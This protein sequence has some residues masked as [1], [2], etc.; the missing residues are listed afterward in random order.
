MNK[1]IKS[2]AKILIGLCVYFGLSGFAMFNGADPSDIASYSASS[3]EKNLVTNLKNKILNSDFAVL[4]EDN[5]VLIV[6]NVS[7][8]ADIDTAKQI[9]S[10]KYSAANIHDFIT[11]GNMLTQSQKSTDKAINQ[12][13]SQLAVKA[14]ANHPEIQTKLQ[15]VYI[16]TFNSKV[17]VLY[18]NARSRAISR[19]T[20]KL[21]TIPNVSSV[22]VVPY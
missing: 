1:S 12:N 2:I 11:V 16:A 22:Q 17:Y 21:Q 13:I 6:G 5:N 3:P 10:S 19:L 20:D 15:N 7:S 8:Q 18:T 9:V 14:L 4:I